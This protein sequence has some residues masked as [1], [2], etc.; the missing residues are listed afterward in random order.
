MG[1]VNDDGF[2]FFLRKMNLELH[3]SHW[4]HANSW[5]EKL[6]KVHVPIKWDDYDK[7]YSD[8]PQ[9][10]KKRHAFRE[11]QH[12]VIRNLEHFDKTWKDN[13]DEQEEFRM[14]NKELRLAALGAGHWSHE[15]Y[16]ILKPDYLRTPTW[17]P[18]KVAPRYSSRRVALGR[19]G[20][21]KPSII[22]LDGDENESKEISNEQ[23]L[24]IK[25]KHTKK[26]TEEDLKPL[27]LQHKVTNQLMKQLDVDA[28]KESN[29]FLVESLRLR[30]QVE[31]T[32]RMKGRDVEDAANDTDLDV[33]ASHLWK[34]TQCVSTS[35]KVNASLTVL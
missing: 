33:D 21:T 31:I 4:E 15:W 6:F 20:P 22:E 34:G 1:G 9:E 14:K 8:L 11:A 27:H 17:I 16:D 29:C 32:Y 23:Q 12:E 24:A 19:A 26:D 2:M 30:R 13:S 18:A 28:K 35:N 25:R 5:W 7:D 10:I 3:K